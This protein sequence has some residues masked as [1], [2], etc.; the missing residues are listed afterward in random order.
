MSFTTL[1]SCDTL[2]FTLQYS[3]NSSANPVWVILEEMV[4]F[5]AKTNVKRMMFCSHCQ[6]VI[7]HNHTTFHYLTLCPLFRDAEVTRWLH[8][9]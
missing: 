3:Q 4:Q 1:A 9:N 8:V 6:E 5:L 2:K 7:S